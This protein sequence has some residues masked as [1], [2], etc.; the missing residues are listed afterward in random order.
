MKHFFLALR[1][2]T[3][4]PLGSDQGQ[5]DDEDLVASLY[6]Y[7]L[8]GVFIGLIL[9]LFYNW[10]KL[11]WPLFLSS[12]LTVTL[13]ILL[14][15]GLHLDGLMD[16][17][18]GLGVR[19][20]RERRLEVMRDSRVGAFGAQAACLLI[21]LKIAALS[22]LSSNLS[23]LALL[24][25][26]AAGRAAIVCLMG[27]SSYARSESGLGKVFVEGTRLSHIVVAVLFFVVVSGI[28]LGEAAAFSALL[29]Q[30]LFFM[31]IRYFF[32]VNFGGVTGDLLGAAC[33]INELA[34]LI[35]VSVL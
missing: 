18:D 10:A 13:W 27:T 24:L 25:A 21:I 31:C 8:V 4:L 1:F 12:A 11:N 34:L 26:P 3:I 16:T 29:F 5:I 23:T 15:A 32:L 28:Y 30:I 35:I 22:A 9:T 17:F 6:Y 7:P 19:G 20:D 33:E 2:L 14:T